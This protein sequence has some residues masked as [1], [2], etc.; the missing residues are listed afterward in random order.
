MSDINL[1]TGERPELD[2][3]DVNL[4]DVDDSYQRDADGRRVN[5]I[6][7]AFRWDHFGAVV[8]ARKPDGRFAVTDGQ[9]RVKAAKLHPN[10]THVPAL[11]TCIDGVLGEAENF[12]VINR[13][14]K[15]VTPVE[16][17]WAGLT[18]GDAACVRISDALGKAGCMVVSGPGDYKPGHTAA[19]AAVGRA[20]ERYG[21]AAVVNALKTIR[22][23]WP[24][25]SR[26]L[27]GSLITALARLHRAN[28]DMDGVRLQRVLGSKTTAELTAAAE[29]FRKLSGGSADTALSKA[30]SELYNKGLS[31]NTIFIGQA[32]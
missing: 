25:D 6:L 31:V 2:W 26:C 32:A 29:G 28:K 9:H 21:D 4:I 23:A 10:V 15:A 3:I 14:R 5:R 19:V 16:T 1:A 17:F 27:R 24:N 7:T 30:I 22:A 8:L 11:I 12:L 20:L 13:E 18:A